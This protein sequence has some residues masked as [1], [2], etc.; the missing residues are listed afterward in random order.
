MQC[1]LGVSDLSCPNFVLSVCPVP[2]L[3]ITC[4]TTMII[5]MSFVS[6]LFP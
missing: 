1:K 4:V 6:V 2:V 3:P 5:C